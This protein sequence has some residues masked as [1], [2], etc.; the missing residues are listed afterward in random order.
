MVVEN[1]AAIAGLAGLA[2]AAKEVRASRGRVSQN[3]PN[4]SKLFC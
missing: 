3:E 4:F 2:L 1:V